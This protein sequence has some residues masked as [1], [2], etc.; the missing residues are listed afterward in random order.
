MAKFDRNVSFGSFRFTHFYLLLFAT[1]MQ[2][3]SAFSLPPLPSLALDD[4]I[5]LRESHFFSETSNWVIPGS[6][7]QGR[8]P[9]SG[10]G[11]ATGRIEKIRTDGGCGTFVCLQAEN[12][13]QGED[14]LS[15]GGSDDWRSDP[16][17]FDNYRDDVIAAAP[18]RPPSFVHYGIR[19][20]DTADSLEELSMFVAHLA[21]RVRSGET[22]YL[23]CWGGKGRAGLVAACL[24]GELY[25]VRAEEAL[26]RVQTY[27]SLRNSGIGTQVLSPET[28][29]Q[30]QQVRDY[31][32][33][34]K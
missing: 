21:G 14:G 10:R 11:S 23:H 25:D 27:C 34:K 28:D 26:E 3:S 4:R 24:L 19:D 7:L 31:F 29:A 18:G 17:P 12:P 32:A 15:F 16:M 5:A 9:S 30:K 33:M 1:A 6:V 22:L 13:P 20:M 2:S 8:H